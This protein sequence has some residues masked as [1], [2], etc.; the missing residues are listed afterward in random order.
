MMSRR[1]VLRLAGMAA[2][3]PALAACD[4]VS[5]P[6]LPE[7]T[8]ERMGLETWSRIRQEMRPTGDA[9]A[10]ARVQG[11]SRKLLAAADQ[12]PGAW[13]V[14]VFAN[15]GVNA[16]VLPGRKIGVLEG[17]VRTAR[18]DGE[19]AA[20]IGHEIGHLQAEH[21]RERLTAEFARGW[22]QQV[23]GFVLNLGDVPFGAEIAALLGVGVEFGVMRPYSRNQE[24]EADRLGL[25][26]M[27][28]AGYDPADAVSLWRRM[29]SMGGGG[30]AILSTHPAPAARIKAIEAA[31]PE[32]ARTGGRI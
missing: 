1:S 16:F 10:R 12:D 27:A 5:V 7:E 18:E 29:E 2:A 3:A 15:P 17:M 9:A 22:V 8:V 31:I 26:T 25:A 32:I 24:L 13:E 21:S 20:V 11:V 6:L 30:P 23:V 28:R 19:L 4:R 14:Q